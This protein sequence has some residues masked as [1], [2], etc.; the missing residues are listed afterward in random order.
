MQAVHKGDP[1]KGCAKTSSTPSFLP[2]LQKADGTGKADGIGKRDGT[3]KTDRAEENGAGSERSAS[4]C[5]E[6][7][8]T[9]RQVIIWEQPAKS[10]ALICFILLNLILGLNS[11]PIMRLIQGGIEMFD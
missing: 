10:A 11:D 9:G 1:L 6:V 5:Q 2:L 4:D 3:G 7:G 8:G